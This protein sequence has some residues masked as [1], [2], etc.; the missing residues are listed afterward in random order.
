[1]G[2]GGPRTAAGEGVCGG[3]LRLSPGVLRWGSVPAHGPG[4][5]TQ[6]HPLLETQQSACREAGHPS[7]ELGKVWVYIQ[8][9]AGGSE[10]Q[11]SRGRGV[12]WVCP[13]GLGTG[14][15]VLDRPVL[16]PH[17]LGS[18]E[19]ETHPV[20]RC[21]LKVSAP[22]DDCLLFLTCSCRPFLILG[23]FRGT[24]TSAVEVKLLFC[25]GPASPLSPPDFASQS[26]SLTLTFLTTTPWPP[27]RFGVRGQSPHGCCPPGGFVGTGRARPCR[28]GCPLAEQQ[29]PNLQGSQAAPP[30]SRH[31]HPPSGRSARLSW[32]PLGS[33][34]SL[35]LVLST[36]GAPSTPQLAR[37]ASGAWNGPQNRVWP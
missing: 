19:K 6:T 8:T 21:M 7:C 22:R 16:D 3:R 27:V 34:L 31:R 24:L 26:P 14:P 15:Q 2:V 11:G 37:L 9:W 5:A 23:A 36:V 17:I 1:M 20:H 25:P 28:P 4:R 18:P 32:R 30:F 29:V 13:G 35:R 12:C 33:P 10:N